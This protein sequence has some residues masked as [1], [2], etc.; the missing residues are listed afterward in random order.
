MLYADK[1]NSNKK[2]IFFY[3]VE[4]EDTSSVPRLLTQVGTPAKK[5]SVCP[6]QAKFLQDEYSGKTAGFRGGGRV[7]GQ[8]VQWVER[9]LVLG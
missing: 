4:A 2:Y 8:R 1:L 7:E 6:F 3:I 9:G 5:I